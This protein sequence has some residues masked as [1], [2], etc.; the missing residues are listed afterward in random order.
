MY[1][2]CKFPLIIKIMW[3]KYYRRK[4]KKCVRI[5]M[6]NEWKNNYG[7]R[8]TRT[9]PNKPE[10]RPCGTR[11]GIVLVSANRHRSGSPIPFGQSSLPR[12]PPPLL[13]PPTTKLPSPPRD[14]KNWSGTQRARE[15]TYTYIFIYTHTHYNSIQAQQSTVRRRYSSITPVRGNYT[16]TA[17][18]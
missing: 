12:P 15:N 5:S 11:E 4:V 1:N 14:N 8:K 17:A 10:A 18:R 7:R 6:R 9:R 2:L 3:L 16:A 13:P